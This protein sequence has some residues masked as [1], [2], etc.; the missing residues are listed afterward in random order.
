LLVARRS[1]DWDHRHEAG[2]DV[3]GVGEVMMLCSHFVLDSLAWL[4]YIMAQIGSDEGRA[5]EASQ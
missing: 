4:S 1:S 2:D 3:E 5:R